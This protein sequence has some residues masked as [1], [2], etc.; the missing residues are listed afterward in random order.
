MNP[1]P[2]SE[3]VE[4]QREN[5]DTIKPFVD[6]AVGGVELNNKILLTQEKIGIFQKV[7]DFFS[8]MKGFLIITIFFILVVVILNAIE[9]IE[10]LYLSHS[11]VDT[12]YLV[13][14]SVLALSLTI[15]SFKSISQIKLLKD[16]KKEQDFFKKQKNEPNR[17]IIVATEKLLKHYELHSNHSVRK[18]VFTLQESIQSSHEYSVIYRSLDE[19]VLNSIDTLAEEKI[20]AASLQ[21]SI[22]TAISPLALLDVIILIWRSFLL[23]KDIANLYGFKPGWITTLSLLKQGSFN[24]FFAGAVELASEYANEIA[25]HS[26]TAKVSTSAGQGVAN[27]I[28]LARLGYGVMK[29]CRP[30]P[31]QSKRSSFIKGV[32]S[33]I[34]EL[35]TKKG[36][37]TPQ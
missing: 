8:S 30:L 9:T 20:K 28:L 24:I 13:A 16:I 23:T 37:N 17:E 5:K 2:F 12:I 10:Q 33:S 18:R 35:L 26:I 36:S 29:A 34:K 14:L 19:L 31:L 15:I 4:E 21:A 1:K 27:G 22:S 11:F 3:V 32:Y 25:G 7:L 6:E